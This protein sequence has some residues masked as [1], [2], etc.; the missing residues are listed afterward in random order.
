LFPSIQA[1]A[2]DRQGIR[3]I[4]RDSFPSITAS[5]AV[6]VAVALLLPA[7]Q[8]ARSAARRAQSVNNLKQIG[9]ALHNFNSSNNHFPADVKDKNGQPLLSWR[10]RILPFVEQQAL[11][12]AF[13]LDEPWDSPHNL[14]L[15]AKMPATFAVPGGDAEPGTTFYR[16]FSGG[17]TIFDPKVPDGTRLES[18]TDGTSNTLAVVEAKE[19]VPWSKP[20]SDVPFDA[21]AKIEAITALIETLGG[22]FPGGF[23]A[24]MCDGSVRFIKESIHPSV[25]QAL[26]T[27]N[28]G[29]VISSDAF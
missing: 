7:V 21:K 16:G 4:S 9:L 15:V 2:V 13:H 1:M 27:R 24:L 23:N 25:L 28:G 8:S 26:V 11:F 22:H 29:E 18:I 20:D 6:P 3:F 12:E 10:V 14:E 19:A 5:S 17:Q